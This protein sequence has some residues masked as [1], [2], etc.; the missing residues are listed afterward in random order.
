MTT[1]KI[2]KLTY[3]IVIICLLF[4]TL[5][6]V[7]SRFIHLGVEY[8]DNAQVKQ[9]ITPGYQASSRKSVSRN[10]NRYIREIPC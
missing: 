7:G 4:G 10:I 2:Q 3:N 8:T 9:H 5:I 1:R 6:Y